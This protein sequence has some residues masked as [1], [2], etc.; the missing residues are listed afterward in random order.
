MENNDAV[1][2]KVDKWK[3]ALLDLTM[4][5]RLI[6]FRTSKTSNLM[7]IKPSSSEIFNKIVVQ[8]KEMNFVPIPPENDEE[9][10]YR[11]VVSLEQTRYR[12][13]VMKRK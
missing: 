9:Q 8:E 12:L 10:E 2:V 5:N 7:L 13:T 3:K 4:R 6:N 1:S 11:S